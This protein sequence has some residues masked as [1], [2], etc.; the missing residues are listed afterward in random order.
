M[1]NLTFSRS[2]RYVRIY[3]S[4]R[5]TQYGNSIWELQIFGTL[6]SGIEDL[7]DEEA[8]S[9]FPNPSDDNSVTLSLASF[10]PEEEVQISVHNMAGD[11]I[12]T[13]LVRIP[14]DRRV[15][16]MMPSGRNTGPGVYII[17]VRGKSL[18]RHTRLVIN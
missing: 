5:L 10:R 2:G 9:V 1:D 11:L 4:A 8:I 16:F 12:C 3:S 17:T 13:D 15:E 18:T 7:V 6:K 14:G